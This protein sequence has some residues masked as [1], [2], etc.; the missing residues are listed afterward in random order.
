MGRA[1]DSGRALRGPTIG[2]RIDVRLMGCA[3]NGGKPP[4]TGWIRQEGAERSL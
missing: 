1:S 4:A 3:G 2:R